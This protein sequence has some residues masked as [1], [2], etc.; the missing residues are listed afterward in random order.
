MAL[1]LILVLSSTGARSPHESATPL[2]P[3][4]GHP[5]SGASQPHSPRSLPKSHREQTARAPRPDQPAETHVLPPH[6][7]Q[8]EF[9]QRA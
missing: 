2:P 6:H 3:R 5:P 4:L 1:N 7:R 8:A 9:E